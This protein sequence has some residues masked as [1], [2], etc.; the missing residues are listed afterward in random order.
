MFTFCLHTR[1]N[2]KDKKVNSRNTNKT[3]KYLQT[4][5]E[6]TVLFEDSRWLKDLSVWRPLRVPTNRSIMLTLKQHVWTRSII[7]LATAN[8]VMMPSLSHTKVQR[9]TQT[10]ES[11][12]WWSSMMNISL[13]TENQTLQPSAAPFYDLLW[14]Q[15]SWSSS[16]LTCHCLQQPLAHMV[17]INRK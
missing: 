11:W 4:V 12:W 1:G 14:L 2:K 6:S 7:P 3:H 15:Q 17:G 5:R 10:E 8:C 13:S 9:R 16:I